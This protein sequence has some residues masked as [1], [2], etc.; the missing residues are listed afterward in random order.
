MYT[1]QQYDKSGQAITLVGKAVKA[2]LLVRPDTCELCGDSPKG[3]AQPGSK[4]LIHGHHWNGYGNALD[5]WWV[6]QSC[7]FKLAGEVFH[8]GI[9]SKEQ[10][11]A[12]VVMP[13]KERVVIR[14][15]C[16]RRLRNLKISK[17]RVPNT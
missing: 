14:N 4:C 8:C 10:A 15:A 9:I 12:I 2:G 6:C 5:V 11:R 13:S 1:P 17:T 3:F 7:N 16:I